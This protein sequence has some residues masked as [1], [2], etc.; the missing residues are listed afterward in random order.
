MWAALASPAR[1]RDCHSGSG[2]ALVCHG[3]ARVVE[4]VGIG[5]GTGVGILTIESGGTFSNATGG[6]VYL[7]NTA[8][9]SFS[10]AGTFI[11]IG[12]LTGGGGGLFSNV[13]GGVFQ[14]FAGNAI[15][16]SGHDVPFTNAGTF[17]IGHGNASL[18]TTALNGTYT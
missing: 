10:N 3:P 7:P 1:H 15:G 18:A 9:S 6:T 17:N 13:Q 4:C 8:G 2:H 16:S 11:N 12:T 14:H 5:N